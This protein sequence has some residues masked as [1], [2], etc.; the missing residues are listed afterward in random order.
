[1]LFIQAFRV[2][3]LYFSFQTYFARIILIVCACLM[4]FACQILDVQT[5]TKVNNASANS[6]DPY[7]YNYCGSGPAYPVIGYTFATWCGP[8]NQIML[9]RRGT[10]MWMFPTE[11]EIDPEKRRR[12]LTESEIKQLSLLAEAAQ[13]SVAPQLSPGVVNYRMGIDFPGRSTKRTYG[14]MDESNAP[15]NLLLKAMLELIPEKPPLPDCGE[16]KPFFDPT[17]FPGDRQPLTPVEID[18]LREIPHASE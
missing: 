4:S 3:I 6:S 13:F 10:L 2:T 18:V 12:A 17:A 14:V 8:S 15:A 7:D 5:T 16:A 1:M 9:G 11:I